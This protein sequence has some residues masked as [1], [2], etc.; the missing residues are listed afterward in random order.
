[1]NRSRLRPLLALALALLS[2]LCWADP[3]AAQGAPKLRLLVAGAPASGLSVKQ[4]ADL[5]EESAYIADDL[6][7]YTVSR[8]YQVEVVAGREL[9]GTVAR[10][11]GKGRRGAGVRAAV[12]ADPHLHSLP[13]IPRIP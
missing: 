11:G 1:M 7:L 5:V 13:Q 6:A 2:A 8:T 12:D 9:A 10:C 3:A 4:A